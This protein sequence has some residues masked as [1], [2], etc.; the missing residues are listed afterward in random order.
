MATEYIFSG[1]AIVVDKPI[2]WLESPSGEYPRCRLECAG[3]FC[4]V[5]EV[6]VADVL[7]QHLSVP[8][9]SEEKSAAHVIAICQ[10]RR[11]EKVIQSLE[12]PD[13]DPAASVKLNRINARESLEKT[14]NAVRIARKRHRNSITLNLPTFPVQPDAAPATSCSCS[15]W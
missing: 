5:G 4:E 2:D 11:G 14:A 12:V 7:S 1:L 9:P 3:I 15:F 13:K 8:G 6:G 10:S